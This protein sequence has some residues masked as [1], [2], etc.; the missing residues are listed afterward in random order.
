MSELIS[1]KSPTLVIQNCNITQEGWELIGKTIV[2]W[3]EQ[4]P[5]LEVRIEYCNIG[6]DLR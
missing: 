5:S 3:R 1:L 2:E 4:N 6:V